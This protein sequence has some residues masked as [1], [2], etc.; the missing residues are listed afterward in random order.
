MSK[1]LCGAAPPVLLSW[2]GCDSRV[3]LSQR[4]WDLWMNPHGAMYT[5]KYLRPQMSPLQQVSEGSPGGTV[6]NQKA[7]P[8]QV[9]L[10]ATVAVAKSTT[11][12]VDL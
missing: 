7:V 11:Q 10:E 3:N 1:Q 6:A 9:H 4:D 8:E 2:T 5:P 12:Q